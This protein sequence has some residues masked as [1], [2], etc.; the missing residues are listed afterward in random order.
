MSIHSKTSESASSRRCGPA[1]RH[2]SHQ[3]RLA[4]LR[5]YPQL[6][7]RAT[8]SLFFAAFLALSVLSAL[9][10]AMS[11]LVSVQWPLYLLFKQAAL[12]FGH[13]YASNQLLLLSSDT[14]A[15]SPLQ[16]PDSAGIT[17]A[18]KLALAVVVRRL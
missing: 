2:V 16:R 17:H 10:L 7:L 11:S 8:H 12:K 15:S 4:V 14:S 5:T 3:S 13:K 6:K 18:T 9:S 1:V